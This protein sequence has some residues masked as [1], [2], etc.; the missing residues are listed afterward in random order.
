ML[1]GLQD[2]LG[3]LEIY[4]LLILTILTLLLALKWFT[5]NETIDSLLYFLD[6]SF[7]GVQL[8]LA[9][10]DGILLSLSSKLL[11]ASG[12]GTL[13]SS[14]LET[15]LTDN[16]HLSRID[17]IVHRVDQ[18]NLIVFDVTC[19]NSLDLWVLE[20]FTDETWVFLRELSDDLG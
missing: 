9:H 2:S 3:N 17:A 10:I 16:I 7:I 14:S 19:D 1:K 6:S 13:I 20:G 8:N 15:L 18:S 12:V 5:S 11:L 4:S